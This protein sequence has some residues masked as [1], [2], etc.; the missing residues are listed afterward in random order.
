LAEQVDDPVDIFGP[1]RVGRRDNDMVTL[2]AIDGAAL[3]YIITPAAM[4]AS[5]TTSFTLLAGP[6]FRLGLLLIVSPDR[7]HPGRL[8]ADNSLSSLC[9]SAEPPLSLNCWLQSRLRRR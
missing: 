8:Q 1:R 9:R 7:S 5:F 3:G 2:A 6:W 4:A